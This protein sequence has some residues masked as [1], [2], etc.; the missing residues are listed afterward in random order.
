MK[1]LALLLLGSVLLIVGCTQFETE[2]TAT[3]DTN[4]IVG[5]STSKICVMTVV[6]GDAVDYQLI[7]GLFIEER[8]PCETLQDCTDYFLQD[9][10]YRSLAPEFESK[11]NCEQVPEPIQPIT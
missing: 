3:P 11:L 6:E 7:A 9:D 8:I 10:N 5:D 4:V 2:N 1:Y